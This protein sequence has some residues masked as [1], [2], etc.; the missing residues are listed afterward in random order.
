MFRPIAFLFILLLGSCQASF[1]QWSIQKGEN[2]SINYLVLR[3]GDSL[4]MTSDN[5]RESQ[6][7]LP[8]PVYQLQTGDVDGDGNIDAL[9]GVIKPTRF[10]PEPA[11]R[12]FV[13]KNYHGHI[14]PLWMGSKLG[15]ILEDFR[16]TGNAVRSLERTTD[17]RFFVCEYTWNGFGFSF[18]RFVIE[19]A[20]KEEAMS[21]LQP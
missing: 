19:N 5:N 3:V 12:L 11:R 2:D 18:L 16:W 10:F 7:H 21:F 14:R 1:A 15:G 9:V 13:F 8:Y 20:T 17:N 4:Q 6:W